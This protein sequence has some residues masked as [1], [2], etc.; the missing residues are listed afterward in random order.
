MATLGELSV[1]TTALA[2]SSAM[3][4]VEDVTSDTP[5]VQ[6]AAYQRTLLRIRKTRDLMAGLEA[7]RAG[8]TLY[9]AQH[10]SESL[11]RYEVR[12]VI[13]GLFNAF[14][15]TVQ[16]SVGIIFQQ[17]PALGEDMPL[18]LV[19]MAENVDGLGTHLAVFARNLTTAAVVDGFAGI[20]T[21]YPRAND[22]RIDRSKASLAATVALDTGA[23]L[24][25]ADEA[26]LGLMPYFLLIKADAALLPIYETV[27]GKRTL[28]LLAIREIA[29]ERKGLFGLAN[30]VRYRVYR[31]TNGVVTYERWTEANGF[32]VRDEGPTVMRNLTGIPWSP[33][34]VGEEVGPNEY[35]P[36]FIDLADLCIEHHNIKTNLLSLISLGCVP[37]QVRIGCPPN[38]DGTYP[39]MILGPAAVI[40]APAIP[41]VPQPIY[42]HSPPMDAVAPAQASLENCK[43]EIG[44]MGASFLTPQPAAQETAAAKRMDKSAETADVSSLSRAVKD[45][46]ESAFGFAGQ[47]IKQDA[48]S[49]SL[50]QE[51]TGEGVNPQIAAVIWAAVA[52]DKMPIEGFISYITTGVLPDDIQQQIDMQRVT[53]EQIAAEDAA[54]AKQ[55]ADKNAAVVDAMVAGVKAPGAAM[56]P[57]TMNIVRGADGKASALTE[58]A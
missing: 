33:L 1:T 37:T 52:A 39:A 27:N 56:K 28:V 31:L 11:A 8:G 46:L 16:A 41:G 30:V 54:L 12:R 57:R 13:A 49:V 18:R 20:I 48:G 58:A 3:P 19:D 17:E 23:P 15:R 29:S 2:S 5:N 38:A 24:D 6:T 44:A 51:L 26:A 9:L 35:M 4:T 10:P 45:C 21:E 34:P 14:A 22:P 25:A 7:I 50:G 43:A 47:Y 32:P 53:Q 40:D 55:S 42:W 36:R